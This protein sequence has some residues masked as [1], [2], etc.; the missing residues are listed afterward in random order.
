MKFVHTQKLFLFILFG[1]CPVLF[2]GACAY[3]WGPAPRSLAGGHRKVAIPIFKNKTMEPG[4][5]VA[6]TNSL[7]QEFNRSKEI[8]IGDE[9]ST[10]AV[11]LGEITSLKNEPAGAKTAA[12][13][14]LPTGAVSATNY[15]TI[16]NVRV[17][18]IR[19][20]DGFEYW[21]SDFRLERVYQAPQVTLSGVNSV[22]P[23]YN[24]SA[25]RQNIDSL[26][27]DLMSE[28]YDRLT[29]SF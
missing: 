9:N 18:Y 10:D 7:I 2:L 13:S 21:K 24:L 29:E 6:M 19:K 28:V 12:D 25:R 22:N 11:I 3:T 26:S 20:S 16:I 23:I 8:R 4:I 15:N 5:E 27:A 14:N 17:R 1:L